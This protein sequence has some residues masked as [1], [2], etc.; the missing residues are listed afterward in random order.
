MALKCQYHNNYY[1]YYYTLFNGLFSNTTWAS[2]YQ[3]S[4]PSLN[5]NEARDYYYYYAAFNVPCVSHKDD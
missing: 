3:K 4:K 1:Y 5:L 2:Q